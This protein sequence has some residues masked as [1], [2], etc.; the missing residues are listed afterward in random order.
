[1]RLSETIGVGRKSSSARKAR[2]EPGE[3]GVEWTPRGGKLK[4]TIALSSPHAFS[5]LTK[6]VFL[7]H[8]ECKRI[9]A[10]PQ[11]DCGDE[12]LRSP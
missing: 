3:C 2:P 5:S 10:S 11:E 8:T 12:A 1:M 9:A 6:R 4:K 7:R